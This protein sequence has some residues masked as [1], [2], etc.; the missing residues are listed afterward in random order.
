MKGKQSSVGIFIFL[1]L[2][3]VVGGIVW[4]VTKR[5]TSSSKDSTQAGETETK[6]NKPTKVVKSDWQAV[7]LNGTD[8]IYVGKVENLDD[9]FVLLKDAYRVTISPSSE[10]NKS[11]VQLVRISEGLHG[12]TN[13][14]RISRQAIVLIEDLRKD[15]EI[16]KLIESYGSQKN[17]SSTKTP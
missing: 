2:I 3:L 17:Q 13:D 10:E 14:L 8:Q 4:A 7:I 12:P 11:T 15:S 1:A 6:N 9:P 5:N 16:L